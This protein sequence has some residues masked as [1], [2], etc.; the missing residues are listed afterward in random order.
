MGNSQRK[1]PIFRARNEKFEL[2]K[3]KSNP[4]FSS[5]AQIYPNSSSSANMSID[6]RYSK[7]VCATDV[8]GKY[9]MLTPFLPA[10]GCN[11]LGFFCDRNN[12]DLSGAYVTCICYGLSVK[13]N[14]CKKPHCTQHYST[15]IC[16]KITGAVCL[17]LLLPVLQLV[18]TRIP[19]WS[20]MA[21][22]SIS[23]GSVG[24]LGSLIIIFVLCSH[25]N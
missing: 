1:G 2:Q 24:G 7:K 14:T 22:D 18:R 21:D 16:V 19:S 17:H 23:Q 5:Q 3:L 12:H 13:I 4:K 15:C 11:Y 8:D 10:W 25:V 6:C 9:Q 20:S